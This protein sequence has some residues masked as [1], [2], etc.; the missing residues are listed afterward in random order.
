MSYTRPIKGSPR[1]SRDFARHV[2]EGS[3]NPGVDYAVRTGTPVVAPTAGVV[4]VDDD[5]PGGAAGV[6]IVLYHNDGGSSDFLHLSRNIVR[7]G[8]RVKQGQ[9]I[10][11][12]GNTGASTGPHLH[13]T[14]RT[15]QI[16]WYGNSGNVD[17]ET[18]IGR[19]PLPAASAAIKWDQARLNVWRKHWKLPTIKVDGRRGPITIAATKDAQRRFGIKVDG[20]A[21]PQTDGFLTRNPPAPVPAPPPPRPVEPVDPEP[22]PEPAP[23]P[24]PVEAEPEPT[25]VEPDPA[26]APEPETPTLP[27]SPEPAPAEPGQPDPPPQHAKPKSYRGP[28]A[29]IL[30]AVLVAIAT[31]VGWFTA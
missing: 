17:G 25:P 8:Q 14:C 18:R 21:G 16:A 24:T 7:N 2:R 31:V 28:I 29:I 22:M 13:W 10:G 27:P 23:D 19:A 3:V 20:V 26:P 30:G 15:R 5:N 12:T 4:K 1:I 11:Y 9:T 6:S